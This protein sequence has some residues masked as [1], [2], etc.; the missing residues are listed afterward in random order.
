MRRRIF[1]ITCLLLGTA[2]LGCGL[3]PRHLLATWSLVASSELL[4]AGHVVEIVRINPNDSPAYRDHRRQL[5]GV[6]DLAITGDFAL[7]GPQVNPVIRA[8]RSNAIRVTA[9]HSHMLD[10]QPTVYFMHF[11][12]SGDAVALAHG[13]RAALDAMASAPAQ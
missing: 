1:V 6:S 8:L 3:D 11:Y 9:L 7:L 4:N 10:A 12:A 5:R 13:L 2:G